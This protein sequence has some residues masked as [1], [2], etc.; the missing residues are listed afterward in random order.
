MKT[1]KFNPIDEAIQI[2]TNNTVLKALLSQQLDVLTACGGKGLCATC[3][4]YI[5]SGSENLTPKTP[6]EERTLAC[7]T[8]SDPNSRLACQCRVLGD[9]T[10]RLPKGM[11]VEKAEDLMNLLGK[12]ATDDVLHPVDGSVLI[13]AGKLITRSR[14]NKLQHLKD[15]VEQLRNSDD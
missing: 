11:Y 8:R 15:Q 14:L 10:V 12:R 1:V 6:R 4:V 13:A 3:H 9:V 2:R 7:L 5:D